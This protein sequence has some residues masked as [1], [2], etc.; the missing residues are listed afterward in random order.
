M[1]STLYSTTQPHTSDEDNQPRLHEEP[2]Q[3]HTTTAEVAT[4]GA[5]LVPRP[6]IGQ[7]PRRHFIVNTYNTQTTAHTHTQR[8]TSPPQAPCLKGRSA[9]T[10]AQNSSK[11]EKYRVIVCL[12]CVFSQRAQPHP[13]LPHSRT[14]PV[15]QDHKH[16]K[17]PASSQ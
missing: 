4:K 16:G 15:G 13:N 6:S 11:S 3:P 12:A 1:A 9:H 10:E 2:C 14:L 17:R 5:V 8:T 7:G